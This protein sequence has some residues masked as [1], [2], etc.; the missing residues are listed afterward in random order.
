MEL[1]LEQLAS[2]VREKFAT[3]IAELQKKV[4]EGKTE[5]R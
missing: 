4:D 5:Y 2:E 3:A 1:T